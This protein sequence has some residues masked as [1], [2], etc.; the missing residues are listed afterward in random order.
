MVGFFFSF[1]LTFQAGA[2]FMKHGG[3]IYDQPSLQVEHTHSQVALFS[4]RAERCI[5]LLF[6]SQFLR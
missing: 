4:P 3:K 2:S 1:L 5:A 6:S